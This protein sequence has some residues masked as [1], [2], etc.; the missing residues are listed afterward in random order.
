MIKNESQVFRPREL[1]ASMISLV[2]ISA[3]FRAYTLVDLDTNEVTVIPNTSEH[4]GG[5]G[6]PPDFIENGHPRHALLRAGTE[7]RFRC[8]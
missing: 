1:V 6:V 7:K 3:G 8:S 4:R 2:S 5:L